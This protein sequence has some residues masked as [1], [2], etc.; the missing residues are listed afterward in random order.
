VREDGR[1]RV[2]IERVFPE[3]DNGEYPIKR[4]PG[5]KVSLKAYVFAD[6]HDVLSVFAFYKHETASVWEKKEL[7]L[8][9]NDEWL[10]EFT[11]DKTGGYLYTIKAWVDHFKTWAAG[12]KKKMEAKQDVK[13]DLII[14]AK[15]I[16]A[17]ALRATAEDTV[18]L[19]KY[20]EN[21]RAGSAAA[22]GAELAELML[23]YPEPDLISEYKKELKIN[24][25]RN[26]TLF[27][28]WYEMFPR[29]CAPAAGKHGTFKDCE[30]MLPEI[31]AMGF[32]V[33]Y[34]PPVHPIGEYKRKGRN[35]ST[36]A[37]KGDPGSPWAVGSRLGGH[38][39]IH[40]ELGT[41][42]D[43]DSLVKAAEKTGIEVALDIAFQCSPDHPYVTEHPEWF[44]KRPDGVIQY[45][46]N[47]PKKYEDIVPFNFETKDYMA[48]W[49]ELKSVFIFWAEKGIKIFRVDNPHTKAFA[50]WDW[51]IKEI[52]AAYPDVI[53]LAEAFTRPKVMHRLAKAGYTQSYT[54][55][56][57]RNTRQELEEYMHELT[58]TESREYFYPNFWPNTPDIL[59]EYIQKSGR[60]GCLIRTVLAATLSSNFG[61]YGG[62]LLLGIKEPFPG[63]EE[64]VDN[65]KYELKKWDLD[66]AGSL[67]NE[68]TL[69]NKIRRENPA[70]Q[71]TWNY[72]ACGSDNPNI[73]FYVKA[74]E[75]RS[76]IIMVAVNLDPHFKQAGYICVPSGV[77]G[78]N[79]DYLVD[80]LLGGGSY[81]WKEEW[82]YVELDPRIK[83]AHIF[84][85][86]KIK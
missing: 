48:L 25:E 72:M 29:S 16:E 86:K 6:G 68:V 80:D 38:K 21:V 13:I 81:T 33:L 50:F 75:D 57:W 34:F 44:L 35:N 46:E 7:K 83:P 24:V 10:G 15:L 9:Y 32:D 63:K 49:A 26:K 76:N 4:V 37:Q 67:K 70:L 31:K 8:L 2:I 18:K 78:L 54:Y 77:L 30:K 36:E 52:K 1:K 64:Y 47:P 51:V 62:P 71:T 79:G 5:E 85:V 73:M 60:A 53:F 56:T 14:G 55:F 61:I 58:Q 28:S 43:F 22:A 45:A 65:E 19:K 17:A 82:N 40:P 23:K 59:H 20:A 74:T 11:V 3:I 66:A 41:F 39:A 27:S 12:L 69:I 42:L 84:R